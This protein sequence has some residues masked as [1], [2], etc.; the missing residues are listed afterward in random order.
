M[1]KQLGT[2]KDKNTLR[3]KNESKKKGNELE[4]KFMSHLAPQKAKTCLSI[5][6]VKL[7]RRN[8]SD[9]TVPEKREIIFVPKYIQVIYSSYFTN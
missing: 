3:Y 9:N 8:L 1:Q 6:M 7:T 4:M 2:I 5:N